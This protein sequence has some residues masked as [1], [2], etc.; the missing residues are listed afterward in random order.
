MIMNCPRNIYHLLPL[1]FALLSPASVLGQSWLT[2]GLIAYYPFSGGPTDSS[3]NGNHGS[4]EG[5]TLTYDRFGSADAAYSFDGISQKILAAIPNIPVGV[6][7]RT[8]SLW[9]KCS[10]N[11][12]DSQYFIPAA[13]GAN[14][15]ARAFGIIADMPPKQW[16]VQFYGGGQDIPS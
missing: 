8:L 6:E 2:N 9:A 16:K 15:D 10:G 14:Q 1:C 4:V 3:G 12:L 13:W 11:P 7:N 5:A